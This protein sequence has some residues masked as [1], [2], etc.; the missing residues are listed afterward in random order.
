MWLARLLPPETAHDVALYGLAWV[1]QLR[2]SK[3][4]E[5]PL[6]QQLWGR[7]VSNPIGLAA[8]L[9]KDAVAVAG[10]ARLGFGVVEIG[11][12]T[13]RPQPGNPKPRLFRLAEDQAVINRMGF[14]SA[15]HEVVFRRL[16][17]YRAKT[18]N[19]GPL[20][21]VNLGKNRESEDPAV[22]YAAGVVRFSGVA[23]YLVVNIS[24][25][26][27][28]GLRSL[29]SAEPLRLLLDRLAEAR[30]RAGLRPPLLLKLAPDLS[31]EERAIIA[32]TAIAY[33]V[34]GLV[35]SNTTITRPPELHSRHRTQSGG[36]SGRPLFALSTGVLADFARLTQGRL[37]LIGVGGV[38][39]GA[40][41][42]AKIRAGASLVQLYTALIYDGPGL[43]RR[44]K[45]ELAALLAR[46]GYGSVT[47]AIASGLTAASTARVRA[48]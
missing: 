12:V 25:P 32:E 27:T 31:G 30:G 19:T 3:K 18:G 7:S 6:R 48:L 33:A 5:P 35:V 15:G 40:D 42:Y 2:G 38:A 1:P 47:A 13:P 8:G 24:S 20:I 26:N 37:T 46:D 29:Q 10:L 34:D 44:I 23:D 9:D 11:S 41:A 43:V 39:S 17:R 21:G 16:D 22:D 14:N 28:P 4:D 36:L 45:A